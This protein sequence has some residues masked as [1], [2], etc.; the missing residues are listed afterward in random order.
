M[1]FFSWFGSKTNQQEQHKNTI[2]CCL[3]HITLLKYYSA[4]STQ[5]TLIKV[6]IECFFPV[7]SNKSNVTSGIDIFCAAV[8][9]SFESLP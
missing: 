6:S 2:N 7:T 9:D 4:L 5:I 3:T 1:E 8:S